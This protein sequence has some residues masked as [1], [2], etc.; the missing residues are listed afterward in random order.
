MK[1]VCNQQDEIIE[2]C[3]AT[4]GFFDGVHIGHRFLINQVKEVA[5]REG[6]HSALITFPI[7]PSQVI[8]GLS[9]TDLLTP[10]KE[11]SE[12]L[13]LTGVDYCFMLSFNSDIA[14][15]SAKEFMTDIL[16]KKFNVKTLMIGYDHRFGHNRSENVDDYR[17]YGKEIGMEVIKAEEYTVDNHNVSSSVVR[18][19][20]FAGN[21]ALA[22]ICLGY[23]YYIDGVVITGNKIGRTLGF[24]TANIQVDDAEKLIPT[25]GVYAVLVEVNGNEYQGMLNIGNRPTMNNGTHRTIEANVFDFDEDIY[26]KNIRVRFIERI[27]SEIKFEGIDKL[28]TQ[29][30]QD[31]AATKSIFT[32][33]KG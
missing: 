11:K 24:P 16:Q 5:A 21:I 20:L 7:H 4:I 10:L 13:A 22:N 31:K 19:A 17:R 9:R 18:K 23:A 29:L 32:T 12:L 1:I 15:L 26:G 25:N 33:L 27:R 30:H 6:L 28:I 8:T 2:P 3:V 14:K